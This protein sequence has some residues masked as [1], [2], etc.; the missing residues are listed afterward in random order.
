MDNRLDI[1]PNGKRARALLE[2][3]LEDVA[4]AIVLQRIGEANASQ[5]LY[6][7]RMC[8]RFK[9]LATDIYILADDWLKIL[10]YVRDGA[11]SGGLVPTAG[12]WHAPP[13]RPREPSS[14]YHQLYLQTLGTLRGIFTTT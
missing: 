1:L 9:G 12:M 5:C 14:P 2:T 11:F 8:V 4:E 7:D 10:P 3:D 6:K 13:N